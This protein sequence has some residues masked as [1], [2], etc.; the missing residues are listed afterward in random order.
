MATSGFR[1][2]FNSE[3]SEM[4]HAAGEETKSTAEVA[5]AY[6]L[7]R[8]WV[9]YL[10]EVRCPREGAVRAKCPL[11]LPWSMSVCVSR[12]RLGLVTMLWPSRWA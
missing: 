2:N 3:R 7:R 4:R 8:Y 9:S 11:A 6:A 10:R 5:G 12:S 1:G